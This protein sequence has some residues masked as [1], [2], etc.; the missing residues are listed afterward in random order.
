LTDARDAALVRVKALSSPAQRPVVDD[1]TVAAFLDASPL[2]NTVTGLGPQDE[3]WDGPWD[4]NLAISKVWDAKA[5]MIAGDYNFSADGASYNK[6]DLL[7]KFLE[8]AQKYLALS[9]PAGGLGTITATATS[10]PYRL[11]AVARQVVP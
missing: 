5:A 10:Y 1:D 9:G 4:E 6:G 3:A 11:D 8:M 7:A 2:V